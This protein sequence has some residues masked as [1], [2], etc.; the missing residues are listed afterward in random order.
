[1]EQ[2][3][4]MCAATPFKVYGTDGNGQ[5]HWLWIKPIPSCCSFQMGEIL[6][7]FQ[8]VGP[9][10]IPRLSPILWIMF[11]KKLLRPGSHLMVETMAKSAQC[12]TRQ[13][14]FIFMTNISHFLKSV[15]KMYHDGH[16][17]SLKILFSSMAN[18]PLLG[19]KKKRKNTWTWTCGPRCKNLFHLQV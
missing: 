9:P 4:S 5:S 14:C 17:G 13:D 19:G 16:M 18:F 6:V 7:W 12:C 10:L 1:M 8:M 15:G 11:M 2:W 3:L